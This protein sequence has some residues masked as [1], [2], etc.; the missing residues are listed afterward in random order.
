M[1]LAGCA[2][3]PI[4]IEHDELSAARAAIEQARTAKAE[5][6]APE[7]LATAQSKLY[8]AAHELSEA[9][10]SDQ[11]EAAEL[12]AQAEDYARQARDVAA[13]DCKEEVTFI[14]LPDENGDVGTISVKAGGTSQTI[15]KAFHS[16]SVRSSGSEP[17]PVRAMD[18]E[19]VKTQYSALLKSQP[20]KPAGYI[21]YFV[22]G[23]SE[24]TASSQ[25]LIPQVIRAA[26]E[27][28]PAE[29]II[30]GHA[31]ST[32][33]KTINMKI[34]TARARAVERLLLEEP[35]SAPGLIYLRFH[36][37]NDPLIPTPDNVPEPRNRR[38]EILIL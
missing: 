20:L 38:V 11:A 37:E 7:L 26:K 17:D 33:S 27:R 29:V 13:K 24:L 31:D 6:C 10:R 12:I 5:R 22:S 32:G 16:T 1:L 28:Q 14:L 18:E 19:Q 9:T 25:A 3:S 2:S 23:S 30:I 15:D 35:D 4:S 21:L 36:G 8:W 34:S